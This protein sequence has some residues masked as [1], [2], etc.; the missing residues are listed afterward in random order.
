[1]KKNSQ[2]ELCIVKSVN[3]FAIKTYHITRNFISS[4]HDENIANTEKEQF[5]GK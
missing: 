4:L 2:L 1:M 3:L 5:S